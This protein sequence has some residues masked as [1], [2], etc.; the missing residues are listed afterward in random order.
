MENLGQ[1]L[2]AA[3]EKKGLSLHE[4]GMTLKINPKILKAI[5]ENDRANLP[6]KTFLRG[7]VRSYAQYLRLDVEQA[8][9]LFHSEYG[10]TRPEDVKLP[11][12]PAKTENPKVDTV[13]TPVATSPRFEKPLK[14]NEDIAL[15]KQSGARWIQIVLAIFILMTIAFVVKMIDK[16]Q[17][18]SEIEVTPVTPIEATTSTTLEN[19]DNNL[20]TPVSTTLPEGG[21][22]LAPS[23]TTLPS[24]T[25][26][27]VLAAVT[28]TSTTVKAVTTTTLAPTTDR[29]SVV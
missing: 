25:T 3:R 13:A 16:Y 28:T 15:P 14:K 22:S 29:K 26:T 4:I 20:S 19:T 6:A 12:V 1:L 9:K 7:F 24:V 21:M 11:D 10:T 23:S 18:E 5:E 8:L 27:S 17:K 2:K